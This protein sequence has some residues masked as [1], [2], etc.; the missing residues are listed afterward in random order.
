MLSLGSYGT[1][2]KATMDGGNYAVKIEDFHEGDE[3]QVNLLVELTMLQSFP[4][5]KLVKFFGAGVF[6]KMQY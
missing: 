3:E 1:V 5:E 4:H 6:V 2:Y